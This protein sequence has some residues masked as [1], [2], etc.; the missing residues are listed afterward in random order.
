MGA[1][2]LKEEYVKKVFSSIDDDNSGFIDPWVRLWPVSGD[3]PI[4]VSG[5]P[6]SFRVGW[7]EF[8]R[9]CRKLDASISAVRAARRPL[10]SRA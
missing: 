3:D 7:Q 10:Y 8:R 5:C 4:N 6:S 1:D 2:E 9:L